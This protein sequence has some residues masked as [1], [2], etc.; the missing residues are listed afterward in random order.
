MNANFKT[1]TLRQIKKQTKKTNNRKNN[2]SGEGHE[3]LPFSKFVT[4]AFNNNL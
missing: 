3:E 1:Q 2:T 4:W